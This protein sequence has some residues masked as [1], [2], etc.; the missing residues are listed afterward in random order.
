[1]FE[2]NVRRQMAL[3]WEGV[4][5]FLMQATNSKFLLHSGVMNVMISQE[6]D[7][8]QLLNIHAGGARG[9]L[10]IT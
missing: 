6:L 1:M 9:S 7:S 10:M 2:L 8:D 3:K 5:L 4:E